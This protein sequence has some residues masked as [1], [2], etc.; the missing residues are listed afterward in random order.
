MKSA[1]L[2]AAVGLLAIGVRLPGLFTELWVD[3]VWS[4]HDVLALH[5]W[6]DIFVT[7]RIDN[8]HHLNGLWLYILGSGRHQALYRLLAFVSGLGTIVIAW[9]LGNR[10]GGVT[11]ALTALV[12]A[13]SFP[14]AYYSSEARGYATAIFLTLLALWWLWRYC[15]GQRWPD[16]A[17]FWISSLLAMMAHA[18]FVLAFI[19]MLVWADSHAQRLTGS[20]RTATRITLRAFVVPGMAI[21]I[22]YLVC[23]RGM[24]IGGG[25]RYS[26]F[27]VATHTLSL[28][29]GGAHADRDHG[30][31]V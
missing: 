7:L 5:S 15:D 25:P 23:L 3:E 28:L 2:I 16:A 8:N 18:S 20:V 6:T 12:F 21:V 11:G 26:L 10:D 1:I 24:R 13:L 9:R 14:L 4:L 29:A 27:E 17:G 22:F 19:G 31:E 30:A